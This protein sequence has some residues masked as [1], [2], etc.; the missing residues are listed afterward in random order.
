[1][2]DRIVEL[3]EIVRFVTPV[4]AKALTLTEADIQSVQDRALTAVDPENIWAREFYI[5]NDRVDRHFEHFDRGHL[6]RFADTI[7]DKSLLIGHEYEGRMAEGLFYKARVGREGGVVWTLGTAYTIK[8]AANEH[9]RALVDGGVQRYGS[10][11]FKPDWAAAVCDIC[12]LPYYMPCKDGAMCEHYAGEEYDAEVCTVAWNWK[13]ARPEQVEAYEYSLV[14]L[15]SQYGAGP[16]KGALDDELAMLDA[17]IV[18]AAA[19]KSALF[20]DRKKVMLVKDKELTD[21]KGAVPV[22]RPKTADRE[23]AWDG[24]KAVSD[25]RDFAG[26]PDKADINWAKY[27]Q[28]FAW[29]DGDAAEDFGS[30]KL[31]HHYV[32]DGTLVVVWSG[33][34]AAGAAIQGARGGVDIPES[35]VDGVKRHLAAHYAQF[36]ET[37]PW[38]QQGDA[39][40]EP[41][42]PEPKDAGD[43]VVPKAKLDQAIAERDVALAGLDKSTAAVTD[44]TAQ[45][46]QKARETADTEA[47]I[48]ELEPKAALADSL[49]A[50]RK[51]EVECKAKAA[52]VDG[53][54]GDL[55]AVT[56]LDR[57]HEIEKAVSAAFDEKFPPLGRA[58][59]PGPGEDTKEVAEDVVIGGPPR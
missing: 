2:K 20:P 17:G 9:I 22:H 8:T 31:P 43:P 58:A 39:A 5:A 3:P 30:Y 36:E 59:I 51:A 38:E 18:P 10:I 4:H 11:G 25:L 15:G 44:L 50:D 6:Q 46:E 55:E 34:A 29:Y 57:L 42:E 12:G 33:V 49:L 13:K 7:V 24:N 23:L 1:L 45:V 56:D 37:P 53:L 16:K 28:G 52:G 21:V 14:Y 27:R 19:R 26:G 40:D 41:D 35:D 47:R 32:E 54:I 48:A